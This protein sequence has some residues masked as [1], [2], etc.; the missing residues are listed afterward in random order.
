M[1][2]T[3]WQFKQSSKSKA[4]L[5]LTLRNYCSLLISCYENLST[6]AKRDEDEYLVQSYKI[7]VKIKYLAEIIQG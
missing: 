4:D 2:D 5:I 6:C 3:I 7:A 1:S